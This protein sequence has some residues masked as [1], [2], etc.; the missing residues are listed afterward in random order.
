VW[1]AASAGEHVL[2]AFEAAADGANTI[3]LTNA[4]FNGPADADGVCEIRVWKAK[5]T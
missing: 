5:R 1:A 3:A 2:G 4:E